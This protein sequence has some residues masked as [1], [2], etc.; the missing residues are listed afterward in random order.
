MQKRDIIVIL[1]G[2]NFPVLLQ[3]YNNS[4][5]VLSKCYPYDRAQL[6]PRGA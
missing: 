3:R 5:C 4:Y 2:Y 1:L 6:W